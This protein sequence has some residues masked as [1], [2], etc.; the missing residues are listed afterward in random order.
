MFIPPKTVLIVSFK[1]CL[2]FAS[3]EILVLRS[4]LNSFLVFQFLSSPTIIHLPKSS[5]GTSIFSNPCVQ[6]FN[7]PSPQLIHFPY[8]INPFQSQRVNQF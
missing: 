5:L 2:H 8:Y 7:L 6:V 3:A 4:Y 1:D